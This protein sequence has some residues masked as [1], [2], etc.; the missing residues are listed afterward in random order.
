MATIINLLAI[1]ALVVSIGCSGFGPRITAQ[2]TIY[3]HVV[4]MDRTGS[5]MDVTNYNALSD[6]EFK[7]GHLTSIVKKIVNGKDDKGRCP[8]VMI[9]VH[10]APLFKNYSFD[11]ISQ[12]HEDFESS[13][14][15]AYP[16][17]LKWNGTMFDA[18]GDH[19]FRVR[20]GQYSPTMG[21]LT[22][23]LYLAADLGKTVAFA[24]P[25]WGDLFT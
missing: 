16:I 18:Y 11:D 14:S 5:P 15:G 6:L 20:Q 8:P 17:F 13:D 2:S 9:Y 24:V 3:N 4:E 19:L 7:N 21:G 10:G 23:P 12:M 1:L 25:S 22:S